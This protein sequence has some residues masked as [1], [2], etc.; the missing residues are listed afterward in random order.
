LRRRELPDEFENTDIRGRELVI[1][2]FI[3]FHPS[4]FIAADRSWSAAQ[5]SALKKMKGYGLCFIF[6]ID[7]Q[8]KFFNFYGNPQFLPHFSFK[9]GGE[10]FVFLLL[11]AREFPVALEMA[12]L[13]PSR[14]QDFSAVPNQTGGHV[15]MGFVVHKWKSCLRGWEVPA[16]RRDRQRRYEVQGTRF[17]VQGTSKCMLG[18]SL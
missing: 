13:G 1:G 2:E 7:L 6:M 16:F 12:S 15:E 3:G 18:F 17:R 9:A 4:D 8:K 11:A 5:P 14:D 10:T